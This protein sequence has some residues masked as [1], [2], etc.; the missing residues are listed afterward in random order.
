[1]G[2]QLTQKERLLLQDQLSHE[3]V[4]IEKYSNYAQQ[5]Q[6]PQLKQLFNQYASHERQHYNTINQLL[7]GQQVTM[8]QGQGQQ[9]TMQAGQGQ[10]MTMQA[11]QGQQQGQYQA[12]RQGQQGGQGMGQGQQQGGQAR[13]GMTMQSDAMLCND[14][15]VSY[16]H[17][18]SFSDQRSG[19]TI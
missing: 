18:K 7:Q 17:L 10:Q 16:T 3:K 4:C 6:D 1:M 14:M 8:Q 2:F 15:P 5:A 12:Q 11:G 19:F 9:M 13:A